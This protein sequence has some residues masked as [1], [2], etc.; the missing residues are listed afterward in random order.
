[1]ALADSAFW[2]ELLRRTLAR[3]DPDLLRP[4]ASRLIKPRNQWPTEDLIER[5]VAGT[6][7]PAILDRRLKDLE[8][9]CRQVLAV[10]GHSRQPCWSFG[11]LVELV[12]ALGHADGVKPLFTLLESGLL[13]PLLTPLAPPAEDQPATVTTRIKSFEQW[14]GFATTSG[15]TVF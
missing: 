3:Y 1:M 8:P 12:I 6:T 15:L 4:V 10:I 11:N 14:L 5:I 7:N 9:A 13:Y 2:S